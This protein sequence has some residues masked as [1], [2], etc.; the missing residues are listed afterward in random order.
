MNIAYEEPLCQKGEPF[1]PRVYSS[2]RKFKTVPV[3]KP[4][5]T[6]P[7]LESTVSGHTWLRQPMCVC[8]CARAPVHA[9][10]VP[11]TDTYCTSAK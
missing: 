4:L 1:F 7:S 8:V 6:Q 10:E 3:C 5:W 9:D 11:L 2:P